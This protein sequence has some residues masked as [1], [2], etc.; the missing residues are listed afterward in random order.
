MARDDS[1]AAHLDRVLGTASQNSSTTPP[2]S[3]RRTYGTQSCRTCSR[4]G[5]RLWGPT[6]SRHSSMNSRPARVALDGSGTTR[7][8]RR[9]R[10]L[11]SRRLDRRV[12]R[13]DPLRPQDHPPSLD[14]PANW[15]VTPRSVRHNLRRWR[16]GRR[17]KAE[18]SV[19]GPT[20]KRPNGSGVVEHPQPRASCQ[21]CGTAIADDGHCGC[22]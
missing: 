14:A 15:S 13:L 16:S 3:L 1:S 8:T 11:N 4:R 7:R 20:S 18:T 10:R 19:A 17:S 21:A 12:A 6:Q 9:A 2:S 5:T 22:S